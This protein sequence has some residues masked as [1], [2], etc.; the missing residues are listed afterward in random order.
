MLQM[1]FGLAVSYAAD[2]PAALQSR[3][4]E[5]EQE[6]AGLKQENSTLKAQLAAKKPEVGE[7][8]LLSFPPQD[9][10]SVGVQTGD[11]KREWNLR[12]CHPPLHPRTVGPSVVRYFPQPGKVTVSVQPVY[13]LDE[14]DKP[15]S[16]EGQVLSI[17]ESSDFQPYQIL[18]S[19]EFASWL[20]AG[21]IPIASGLL[22]FYTKRPPGDR[23][24][25]T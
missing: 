8:A 21:G 22:M 5:L 10:I 14:F 18:A 3:I 20:I 2:D 15:F 25:I 6:N 12:A 16:L 4:Q 17:T 19:T 9:R 24:R 1:S 7:C 11:G 23:I 13:N